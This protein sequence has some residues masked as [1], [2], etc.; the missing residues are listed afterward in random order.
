MRIELLSMLEHLS[1]C[2]DT[3]ARHLTNDQLIPFA[4]HIQDAYT[5]IRLQLFPQFRDEH[6]QATANYDAFIFPHFF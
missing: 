4:M 2:S 1:K 6:I 5:R 3:P